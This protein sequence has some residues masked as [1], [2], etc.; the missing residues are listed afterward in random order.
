VSSGA[1]VFDNEHPSASSP[2]KASALKESS[3]AYD[4]LDNQVDDVQKA[5][6][7]LQDVKNTYIKEKTEFEEKQKM[8]FKT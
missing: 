4:P 3:V 6:F 1:S 7:E 5:I 2:F 8:G